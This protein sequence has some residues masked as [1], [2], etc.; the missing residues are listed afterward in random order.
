[1][2]EFI[3]NLLGIGPQV[4]VKALIREGAKVVDVRTPAEYQ[5]GHI[6]KSMN[7]PL[8]TLANNLNKLGKDEVIITCCASGMRSG[9]ARR[10]LKSYG[11]KNVH[12]GGTWSSLQ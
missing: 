5:Q 11:Y 4:D 10:M 1:M 7:I 8:Q 9:A 2:F 12:N 3:K 6:K